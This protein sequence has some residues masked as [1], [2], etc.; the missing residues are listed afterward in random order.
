MKSRHLFFAAVLALS[1][2]RLLADETGAEA[3]TLAQAHE[4]AL[5]N[6]PS[7]AAANYQA[8]AAGEVVR[9]TRAGRWPQ[10]TL[11]GSAVDA[12]ADDTR[13]LAGG[14]NNPSVFD[15]TA[16]GAGLSQMITDFVR[17]P[18]LI[19]SSSLQAQ[20][21]GALY[22]RIGSSK[23]PQITGPACAIRCLPT[24]PLELARP[25]GKRSDFE[26]SSS[27]GVSIA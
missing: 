5:R 12:G 10:I 13:I 22:W 20:A 15:R 18:N 4:I 26:F 1:T 17:T 16:A 2:S 27:R 3:L 21:G 6:H 25:S 11:Y 9:Q 14:I 7:I 19:A 23:R 24:M 8:Q